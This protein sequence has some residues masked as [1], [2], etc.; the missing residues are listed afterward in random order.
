MHDYKAPLRDQLTPRRLT[1]AMWDFAYLL[2]RNTGEGY[3]DW[4]ERLDELVDRGY[5]TVRIDAFPDLILASQNG[6]E[7]FSFP[8]LNR[9]WFMWDNNAPT[10]VRPAEQV[11]QFVGKAAKHGLKVILST[12]WWGGKINIWARSPQEITEAWKATLR[13]MDR[14]GLADDIL[15]VDITNEAHLPLSDLEPESEGW[16]PGEPRRWTLTEAKRRWIGKT[17]DGILSSLQAEFPHY[18]S[19]MSFTGGNPDEVGRL[20]LQHA[21]VLEYHLFTEDP[22]FLVRTRFNEELSPAIRAPAAVRGLRR[23][24][25]HRDVS[26]VHAARRHHHGPR[27]SH[28]GQMDVAEDPANHGGGRAVVRAR[29]EHGIGSPMVHDGAC[30]PGLGMVQAMVRGACRD[31][32]RGRLLGHDDLQLCRPAIYP[33][34][35]RQAVAPGTEPKIPGKLMSA[36][37]A[38]RP[39]RVVWRPILL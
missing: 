24:S 8:S 17:C 20:C 27:G 21:D 37:G 39:H 16:A 32:G 3:E 6:H 19:T 10:T 31:V 13:L 34:L 15:Y 11:P 36:D 7:A 28:D 23:K 38:I 14:E 18:R 25:V 29:D 4:D 33:A 9:P 5:N 35:G 12:W 22:R 2:R 26:S 30:G 1:I